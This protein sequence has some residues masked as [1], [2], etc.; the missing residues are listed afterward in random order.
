MQG[1]QQRPGQPV[2]CRQEEAGGCGGAHSDKE[3]VLTP[4]GP[5]GQAGGFGPTEEKLSPYKEGGQDFTSFASQ[6]KHDENV[7]RIRDFYAEQ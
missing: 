4:E 3:R 1:F 5:S 7:S 6:Q 2:F